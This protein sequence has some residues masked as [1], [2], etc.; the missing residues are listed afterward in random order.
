MKRTCC[1]AVL[2]LFAASAAIAAGATRLFPAKFGSLYGY[3]DARGHTVIEPQF[4]I[5][6]DFFDGLAA[7]AGEDGKYGY[8]DPSGRFVIAPRYTLANDFHAGFAVVQLDDAVAF[9]RR[10]GTVAFTTD[11]ATDGYFS[12]GLALVT[13]GEESGYIDE[14]GTMVIAP[15]FKEGA[16]RFSGGFAPVRVVEKLP[17]GNRNTFWT[18]VDRTGKLLDGRFV[19]ALGFG[20]GVAPVSNGSGWGFVDTTGAFA[21]PPRFAFAAPFAERL[22]CVGTLTGDG[23]TRFGFIDR[24]G[25]LVIPYAFSIARDFSEGLAAVK[26]GDTWGYID[27]NGRTVIPFKYSS[28]FDFHDGMARAAITTA[29][30]R[31]EV[32]LDQHGRVVWQE[33]IAKS[34]AS[35]ETAR[36]VHAAG[37]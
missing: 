10:D 24:T 28:A 36:R 29:S 2:L 21:I 37:K 4:K 12:E 15:R 33:P 5:A 7:V 3:I 17:D 25:S 30:G 27:R 14:S 16:G 22:A 32:Y 19:L 8:I 35:T 31:R 11:L 20:S 23:L 6:G 26:S 18:F 34:D 9:L 13:K 1:T